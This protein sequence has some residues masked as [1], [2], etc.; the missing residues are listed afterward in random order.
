MQ[1]FEFVV[2]EWI[3]WWRHN[4][5]RLSSITNIFSGRS[6]YQIAVFKSN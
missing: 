2:A 3:R 5:T 1:L 4:T 6:A